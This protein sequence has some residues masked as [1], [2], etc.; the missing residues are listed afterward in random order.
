MTLTTSR[1]YWLIALLLSLIMHSCNALFDEDMIGFD[2][3]NEASILDQR[4]TYINEAIDV[5]GT[6][7][8]LNL[9]SVPIEQVSLCLTPQYK[10]EDG[11]TTLIDGVYEQDLIIEEGEL[12]CINV[13][14][15][16]TGG[17]KLDGGTLVVLGSAKLNWL[18][19]LSGVVIVNPSGTIESAGFNLNEHITF[20]NY[21]EI[22][23]PPWASLVLSG[24]FENYAEFVARSVYV[25]DGAQFYN[26]GTLKITQNASI[27]STLQNFGTVNV[28]NFLHLN[29]R[30]SL[31]NRCTLLVGG[32][33]TH[34]G[35]L[36]NYA[37][38]E[39][40]E[41]FYV[42]ENDKFVMQSG[43]LIKANQVFIN[44]DISS[45]DEGLSVIYAQDEILHRKGN[46][47]NNVLLTHNEED[48]YL[49]SS[50]CSPGIGREPRFSLLFELEAP[51]LDGETLS[52][53][54]VQSIGDKVLISYHLNGE[55]YGAAMDVLRLNGNE[56]PELV[57]TLFA[58][59]YDFNEFKI[60]NVV[61]NGLRRMWVVGAKN[62]VDNAAVLLE[63][64]LKDGEIH[65]PQYRMLSLQGSSGNSVVK[66][67]HNLL[68]I[69][70]SQGGLT[71]IDYRS[72]TLSAFSPISNAKY[73][74][75]LDD[76]LVCLIAGEDSAQLMYFASGDYS[77]PCASK[78]ITPISPYN[79]KLVVF[80][81]EAKS[82]VSCATSGL[83][84]YDSHSLTEVG[85]YSQNVSSTN[86]VSCDRNFVYLANGADGLHILEKNRLN[87]IGHYAFDGS[88]N[89]V[90]I[91]GQYIFLADGRGGLKVVYRE[92]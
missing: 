17:V 9:R 81:D 76:D 71:Q 24:Q 66:H 30:G 22:I 20:A 23:M 58:P 1:F 3:E 16:F 65:D 68:T 91:L 42:N 56:R 21:G 41:R 87:K 53:T 15:E 57:Q 5:L 51:E 28:G 88:A 29:A 73:L 80:L 44:D 69:S 67:G 86:G 82:Y 50:D 75:S 63:M 79:G 27:S 7:V 70:G 74:S 92:Q 59:S 19:A 45:V 43:A 83:K 64:Q 34:N 39:I 60:D 84:V 26:S 31:L 89:Y 12:V 2:I 37:Y 72:F 25:N 6:D 61:T 10:I 35:E 11:Y 52:A 48:C 54:C 38:L 32:N 77:E 36:Y 55:K 47:A 8:D 4:V 78:K 14:G 13:T 46:I 90:S 33:M 40:G 85:E 49:P 62:T 18:T